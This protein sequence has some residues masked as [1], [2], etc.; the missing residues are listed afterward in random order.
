M[1]VFP[2]VSRPARS[3]RLG[4]S[5]R[6]TP[7]RPWGRPARKLPKG[8]SEGDHPPVLKLLRR[9]NSVQ[10]AKFGTEIRNAMETAQRCF[11]RGSFSQ[12]QPPHTRQKYMNKNM[13]TKLPN[14]PC[15]KH[16]GPYFVQ[17]FVHIFALYVGGAGV[18]SVF[19]LVSAPVK[20]GR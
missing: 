5:A 1:F 13:A 4:T 6:M 9:V 17:M 12:P 19:L 3:F 10:A 16:L 2:K 18:T 14:L 7:R 15:L 11:F 8:P 20:R